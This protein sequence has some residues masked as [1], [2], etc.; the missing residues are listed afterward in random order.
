MSNDIDDLLARTESLFVNLGYPKEIKPD[1]RET[2][3]FSYAL[4]KEPPEKHNDIFKSMY[5]Y[6]RQA[7]TAESVASSFLSLYSLSDYEAAAAHIKKVQFISGSLTSVFYSS[8]ESYNNS[9]R[10][11][12]SQMKDRIHNIKTAELAIQRLEEQP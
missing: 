4:A 9:H 6:D 12:I 5:R 1:K 7:I 2:Y 3:L 11:Y 10:A 8:C